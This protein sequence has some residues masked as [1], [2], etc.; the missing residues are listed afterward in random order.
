MKKIFTTILV[1]LTFYSILPQQE[2]KIMAYN[3]LNYDSNSDTSRNTYF[4]EIIDAS[5]PD[6]LVVEEIQ[7]Q[8]SVNAFLNNVMKAVNANF[9]AGS[10]IANPIINTYDN[11]ENAIFY[12]SSKF[13]FITNTVISTDLRDINEFKV[14]HK[15]SGDTLRIY[16]AHLKASQGVDSKGV[17]NEDRR[18]AEVDELRKVTDTLPNG[19][20]FIFVGDF[21]FY[22]S[23]EPGYSK[24]LDKTKIGYFLDPINKPGNW[25]ED[26]SFAS[27]HTQATR[28]SFGGLDD[29]FDFIL[30]SQAVKDA[31]GIVYQ[32]GTYKSF[33]ND[34]NH[35]NKSI[36]DPP[37]NTAVST[38]V[39]DAL[40]N[41][42][43]H[44]PVIATFQ[45]YNVTGIK[46]NNISPPQSFSLSQNFPNPFNPST[47]INYSIPAIERRGSSLYNVT[48]KIYDLLGIEVA[49]LVNEE[50]SAG[51]YQVNFNT[52][53]LSA[54][55]QDL[56]SGVY[57]YRLTAI[58]GTVNFV[59]TKKM[60]LLK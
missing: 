56:T 1:L 24:L 60:I 46:D 48:L 2:A 23:S 35:F 26:V 9:S 43:D 13:K 58:S 19:K 5:Q 29:R 49:T 34:G 42:S 44:L 17:P 39:A 15:I 21:N 4:R 32:T 38:T 22:N 45:F 54:G 11:N 41:A 40:Y 12:N 18:A 50:K 14:V 16:A 47:I 33:G 55:R 51:N 31:G 53:N 36:N 25:H 27:I 57:F 20:D 10:F 7:N 37:T 30:I 59:E 52:Q 3:L 6:V 8:Y 28:K